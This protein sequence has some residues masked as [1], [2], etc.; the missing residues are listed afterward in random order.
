LG[1]KSQVATTGGRV[2]AEAESNGLRSVMI[3]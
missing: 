3:A 1:G 2:S